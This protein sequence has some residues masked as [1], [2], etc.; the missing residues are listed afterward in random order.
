PRAGPRPVAPHRARRCRRARATPAGA[1]TVPVLALDTST[2]LGSV[3]LARDAE[4]LG[5]IVLGVRVRHSE[6]LL[7][8]IHT[9]LAGAGLTPR[10]LGGVVVGAGPGSFTGVRI[11]AATA[12]GLVHAAGIPLRACSSLAALAAA[13]ATHD[14]PVCA[15]F[16]ARRDEVYAACYRFPG[17]ARMET[18]LDPAARHLDDVLRDVLALA[19]IFTGDGALRH[20]GRI[21]AAG[22][23]VAPPHL[24]IPRAS[25]LLWLAALHPDRGLI[26]DPARWEPAYVRPPGIDRRARP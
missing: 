4:L 25:C 7:P 12:K 16:D 26:D 11:A 23:T 18:L 5:E 3:A 2:L 19:P 9:V 20:A 21:R 6:A 22:G 24:A 15:L 17:Y 10:D 14:R 13:A 1:V 8:A